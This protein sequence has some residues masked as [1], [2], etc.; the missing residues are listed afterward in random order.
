MNPEEK[1]EYFRLK[2]I[3]CRINKSSL[4]NNKIWLKNMS[5]EEKR[6]Y[7]RNKTRESRKR[8]L[9]LSLSTNN[10]I[11]NFDRLDYLLDDEIFQVSQWIKTEEEFFDED[12]YAYIEKTNQL[13]DYLEISANKRYRERIRIMNRDRNFNF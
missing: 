11:K 2:Q 7:I 10:I 12:D 13:S 3:D 9:D 6:E 8:K 5:L 4:K 1:R